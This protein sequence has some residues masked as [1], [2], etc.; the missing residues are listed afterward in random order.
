MRT[1]QRSTRRGL[2]HSHNGRW[3]VRVNQDAICETVIKQFDLVIP[4]FYHRDNRLQ[5]YIDSVDRNGN[6][7]QV[8]R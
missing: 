4:G 3:W 1:G 5:G 8:L 7:E 2:P 6:R